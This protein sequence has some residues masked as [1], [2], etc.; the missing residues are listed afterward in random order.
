MNW[1]KEPKEGAGEMEW[2]ELDSIKITGNYITGEPWQGT[3]KD[4]LNDVY[5]DGLEC[6]HPDYNI[7][8]SVFGRFGIKS[9]GIEAKP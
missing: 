6:S 7:E 9:I 4:L 5:L 1:E 2:I 3:L 8:D